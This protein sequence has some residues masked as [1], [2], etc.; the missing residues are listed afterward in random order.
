MNLQKTGLAVAV[1]ALLFSGA[2]LANNSNDSFGS[3]DVASHN[4]VLSN[5]AVASNNNT[6]NH[7]N[8]NT[9]IGNGDDGNS[10]NENGN[11][12]NTTTIGGGDDG[13]SFSYNENGDDGNNSWSDS[14]NTTTTT[15]N[16]SISLESDM[17]VADADLNGSISNV[18]AT[19]TQL[20][21]FGYQRVSSANSLDGF[22]GTAGITTVGQN[23]GA[24]SMVQQAV[25]TNASVFT[26]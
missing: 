1:S 13:N 7:T 14:L 12:G 15:T 24:N 26:K 19:N 8:T 22:S 20:A 11:D 9:T 25:T 23:A 10:Y 4:D 3:D 16:T 18:S 21:L 17:V 2:V 6:H 5:N